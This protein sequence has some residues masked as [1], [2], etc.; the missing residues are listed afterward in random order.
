MPRVK[1]ETALYIKLGR[2]G[3]W[4]ADCI[5]NGT[6]RFGYRETP[7]DACLKSDW[8]AVQRERQ[9]SRGNRNVAKS[10]TNQIRYF[11]ESDSRVLWVTF[12]KHAL[13]WCFAQKGVTKLGDGTKIRKTVS[14]WK[15]IDINDQQLSV[16]TLSGKLLSMQGFRGTICQVKEFRYLLRRINADEHPDVLAAKHA[17]QSL[18]ASLESVIATLT[19][20]DFELLVDLIF[21]QAG[22][23]RVGAIGATTKAIDLDLLSPLSSERYGVQIK[24]QATRKV[25]ESYRDDRLANMQ[26]FARCYFVVHSPAPDLQVVSTGD[27]DDVRLLLPGDIAQLTAKYGLSDWVIDKAG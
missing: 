21:R 18:H 14:G 19:W 6:L 3:D 1:A 10:D 20:K 2:G 15:A 11:Y 5:K 7:H 13:W 8:T 4:E 16:S 22:W 25:Y 24:S 23:R 26:G 27:N 17:L 12:Y 9:E